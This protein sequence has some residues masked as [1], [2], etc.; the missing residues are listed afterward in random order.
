[1]NNRLKVGMFK[2]LNNFITSE[3]YHKYGQF[4]S[5]IRSRSQVIMCLNTAPYVITYIFEA[6]LM[7]FMY[8]YY[9]VFLPFPF[10]ECRWII[11]Y[12]YFYKQSIKRSIIQFW[13]YSARR[14]MIGMKIDSWLMFH[15]TPSFHL[16]C[17]MTSQSWVN[18]WCARC[19]ALLRERERERERNS[20]SSVIDPFVF[21]NLRS[22][23]H[24]AHYKLGTAQNP[25][26]IQWRSSF[27]HCCPINFAAKSNE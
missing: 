22:L 5:T 3:N 7:L 14:Q 12:F 17:K 25:T 21:S 13:P 26:E 10:R 9:Y 6:I 11:R 1:M 2:F 16:S 15:V 23:P 19:V 27:E 24:L 18:W 8:Y 4:V 20:D